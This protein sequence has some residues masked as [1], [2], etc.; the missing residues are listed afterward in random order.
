MSSISPPSKGSNT[1]ESYGGRK[2]VLETI[3]SLSNAGRPKSSK[4]RRREI[5][6]KLQ[7]M[8]SYHCTHKW[9]QTHSAKRSKEE[10]NKRLF[11]ASHSREEG[12]V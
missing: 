9:Q 10:G 4:T 2:D 8:C 6:L 5:T 11:G 7:R 12:G 3:V 1:T